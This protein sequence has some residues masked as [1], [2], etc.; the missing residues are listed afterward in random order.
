MTIIAAMG[1]NSITRELGHKR[2][3]PLR[4]I[5]NKLEKQHLV[6]GLTKSNDENTSYPEACCPVC[7]EDFMTP[8]LK[9]IPGS[10]KAIQL[11]EKPLKL[12]CG[13]IICINCLHMIINLKGGGERKCPLCRRQIHKSISTIPL[14]LSDGQSDILGG[15]CCAI[16]LY[17]CINPT[18][19]ETPKALNEWI[20]SP[21]LE[22]L[23]DEGQ[24]PEE[25]LYI[26]IM[27]DAVKYYYSS[28]KGG[29]LRNLPCGNRSSLGKGFPTRGLDS[30]LDGSG[31]MR[32]YR[33]L[34]ARNT[35]ML[36]RRE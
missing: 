27:K 24:A 23:I 16:R 11:H 17:I 21:L 19:P 22:Q 15:L 12:Q 3:T 29:Q 8:G 10:N 30:D 9:A 32:S 13:H 1:E 25:Q 28:F 20:H 31:V 2:T 26:T 4:W 33:D 34:M 18:K 7:L 35:A 5:L 6:D 36:Q 14:F